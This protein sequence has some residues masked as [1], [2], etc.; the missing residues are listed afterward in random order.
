[1]ADTVRASIQKLKIIIDPLRKNKGWNRQDYRWYEAANVTMPTLKRF[2]RGIAIQKQCFIDICKAVGWENWQQVVDHSPVQQQQQI[3]S[4]C[5]YDDD[6]VGR[7]ELITQLVTRVQG[8][9]R[10]LILTGITGIGKTALAERLAWTLQCDFP[11][12]FRVKF[13][14]QENTDFASVTA[15]LL[16]SSGQ[17]V[18]SD[19]RKEPQRL[20]NWLVSRL[21]GNQYLV[22]MDALE[23]I[24][25]GNVETGWSDFQDEWWEKFFQKLL[26]TSSCQSRI[27]LTSQDLPAQLE[28][29]GFRYPKCWYCQL[30]K[31][32]TELEQLEF[33]EKI[34][35]D[36]EPS[37]GVNF[38]KRIGAAYEGHPL[39]LRVIGGEIANQP[40][41]GNVLAYWKKYGHEV[42]E[43]EGIQEQT[44]VE[45]IDDQVKLDRY[46]RHL[47][48]AVK[49]RIERTFERLANDV[50]NAYVMLCY[51]S[52]YRRPVP[53]MFWLTTLERLGWNETQQQLALDVLR[54]RYLIEEELDSNDDL[55]LRQHNLI[56]SVA[57]EHLKKSNNWGQA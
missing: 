11:E 41:K 42:E 39:A 45:S 57:L 35:L 12:S 52:V 14:S 53:E 4:Y 18:T 25:Q 46:T 32:F 5:D 50:F 31:G 54:D 30:L 34:G 28:S 49:Q 29:L 24:L 47:Q 3:S 16:I 20:L 33:F 51:G 7:A 19:D 48:R 15:Q 38:L 10:V 55:L 26:S 36:I 40:F 21:Q 8:S 27:I 56:R 22:M 1:M 37:D 6:W 43:V 23:L 13:D 9:C 2:W 44:E 17:T